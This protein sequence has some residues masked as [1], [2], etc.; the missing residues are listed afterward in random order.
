MNIGVLLSIFDPLLNWIRTL[1]QPVRGT[2]ILCAVV[3]GFVC[4]AR[5]INVGK[6]HAERPVK[7]VMLGLSIIFFGVAV[8]FGVV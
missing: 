1:G 3:L 6:N 4:F 5:C 8:V 2:V 7:W